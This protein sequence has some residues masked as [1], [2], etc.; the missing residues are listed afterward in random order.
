MSDEPADPFTD[1]VAVAVELVSC[2]EAGLD[3]AVIE[4][5]VIS[6]AGGR[7]KRRRLAAALAANPSV[8]I[9]GRSPAPRVV[10][11]LLIALRKA[12]AVSISPPCCA[13]C[14]KRLSSLQRR[15]EDWYCGVCGPTLQPCAA[16][17]NT[18]TVSSRDR[19][20]RPRCVG[21]PPNEGFDPVDIVVGLVTTVDPALSTDTVATAVGVVTSHAGQRRQLAWALEDRPEL[22]TGAGAETPVPTVLRLIDALCDAGAQGIVRPSCPHCGRVIALVKPRDGVR[23]CRN[24]VAKSRAEPCSS[25]GAVREPATRDSHGDP[26]CPYCLIIDPANQESCTACHRRRPVAVRRGDG[27]LCATCRPVK[28]MTCAICD[29]VAPCEVSEATGKPR[30]HACQ[31]RWMSCSG[32]GEVRP[33]GGGTMQTP[34]CAACLPGDPSRWSPCVSCGGI[35]RL[36]SGS[37]TRC[38][39][40]QRVRRLLDDGTGRVRAELQALHQTLVAVERPATVSSWLAK[41]GASAV[42]ASLASSEQPLSHQALDGLLPTKPVEHLRAMLVAT[43]ALPP[44]DEHLVRLERWI[45]TAVD[46]DAN[47]Q[48]KQLLHR[49]AIWHLLRRLRQRNRGAHATHSQAVAV[50]Q[51]VRAAAGLL[52][53]LAAH[54]L[55]LGS[56]RQGDLE[57]WL[58]SDKATGRR[59]AGHFIRWANSQKLTV[60]ELPAVRWDGPSGII[61]TEARWAQT[62]RLLHDATIDPDDRVAGLLVLLYAQRPAAISRL[63]LTHIQDGDDHVRLHLGD[64]PVVAP[65]PLATLVRELVTCRQGHAV[66]G[67]QG[68]SP[69]LFPGGQPGRPISAYQLGERLRLIGLRPA[70]AR[71]AALF[72]LATELPAALLARMLGIHIAVAVAWQR[73][74]AG[75]WTSYAADVARRPDHPTAP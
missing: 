37:C 62:R 63:S 13:G 71:S 41:Q 39:L 47:P 60:L 35:E 11:E 12:E 75:D 58:A 21:C 42:L 26:L 65:E 28:T 4:K 74:S 44:R 25:C 49:Y 66:L 69:W 31:Q 45:V 32:C 16:C 59:E 36:R 34:L 73:A 56:A 5:V 50:Q 53:W 6:V 30:C 17:G 29:R 15:G 20:G 57:T 19:A 70:Q 43:G 7:S 10:G 72:Q 52:D 40:D 55:T 61:D 2:A 9:D 27:P 48:D 22:L 67:D 46:E 54:E 18:R 8:L 14:S 51:H 23:L 68:H 1:P 24:C 64:E 3:V 33:V 38:V